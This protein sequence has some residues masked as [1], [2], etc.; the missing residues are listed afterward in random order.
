M[1]AVPKKITDVVDARH[2]RRCVRCGPSLAAIS[3]S[4]HHRQRRAV[5]GHLVVCLTLLCGSGITG[6][7]GWAHANPKAA[8]VGGYIVPTHVD[9]LAEIPVLIRWPEVD[10]F[11]PVWVLLDELGGRDRIPEAIALELLASFRSHRN[12]S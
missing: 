10:P 7:H 5:G 8:R 1:S 6:C 9:D 12:G 2:G 3:G 11:N 4:R